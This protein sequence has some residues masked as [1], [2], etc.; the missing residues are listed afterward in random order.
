MIQCNL[1]DVLTPRSEHYGMGIHS[2]RY[3]DSI[4]LREWRVWSSY[5]RFQG[6][7]LCVQGCYEG[8]KGCDW[9]SHDFVTTMCCDFNKEWH[10]LSGFTEFRKQG[11]L[12]CGLHQIFN[13]SL[14]KSAIYIRC[15]RVHISLDVLRIFKNNN[16]NVYALPCHSIGKLQPLHVVSVVVFKAA[17]KSFVARC[18]SVSDN[19]SVEIFPFA[20]F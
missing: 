1:G 2:S 10:R 7:V 8:R 15:D 12:F 17:L 13:L 6:Q 16:V 14:S 9:D 11:I 20:L 3:D 18:T 4:H 5:F 19:A